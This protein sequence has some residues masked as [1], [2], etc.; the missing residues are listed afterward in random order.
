MSIVSTV[1]CEVCKQ[2]IKSNEQTFGVMGNVYTLDFNNHVAEDQFL[3][4]GL[5]GGSWPN[6]E[7]PILHFHLECFS[8][9][10]INLPAKVTIR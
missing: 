10:I 9:H 8:N 1:Q 5:F 4:G 7:P 6:D 3:G 2:E